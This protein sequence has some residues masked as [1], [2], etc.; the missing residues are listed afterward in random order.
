MIAQFR[1]N[2]TAHSNTSHSKVFQKKLTTDATKTISTW[3][4]STEKNE[5]E[6]L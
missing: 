5:K 6:L 4:D 2:T 3:Q 1:P